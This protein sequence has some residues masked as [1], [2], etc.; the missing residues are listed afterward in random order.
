[1]ARLR[2]H[3]PRQKDG[4]GYFGL[5][6]V[7]QRERL[8]G[9]ALEVLFGLLTFVRL[10]N[11]RLFCVFDSCHKSF[12]CDNGTAG[13]M[14]SRPSEAGCF[15]FVPRWSD[16]WKQLVMSSHTSEGGWGLGGSLF[17]RTSVAEVGRCGG[18][19]P[20]PIH[21]F[22]SLQRLDSRWWPV[23]VSIQSESLISTPGLSGIGEAALLFFAA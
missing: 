8:S 2:R 13:L 5:C 23:V 21:I 17:S 22:A 18:S 1:M 10:T 19:L 16:P 7:L 15:F 11:R 12:S 3:V 9:R 4:G 14:S 20:R 6:P